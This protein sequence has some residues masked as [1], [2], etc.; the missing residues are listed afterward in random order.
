MASKIKKSYSLQM[1][2][3]LYPYIKPYRFVLFLAVI[4]LVINGA[5]D[6]GL[7]ALIKPLLDNGL[8]DKE[9]SLVLWI[10]VGIVFLIA[11]RGLTN[12]VSNYSLAW[13]SGKVV[14][15]F[16]QL[17]FAHYL[18]LPA[19]Y[20]DQKSIGDQISVIT[21]NAEMVSQAS[22][23][24]LI[25]IVRE[26][27]YGL[28]L[29]AVMFY[30]SWQ[31]SLIIL[32]VIPIV[33]FIA[34]FIAK[35]IKKVIRKIQSL[36]GQITTETD[37]M[38]KGHKEVLI[39]NAQAFEKQRF[40]KTIQN[41]RKTNLKMLAI[42]NL[43]SPITQVVAGIGLGLVIYTV[44]KSMLDITPGSF[45]L[46]FSAM[47]ALMR[48]MRELTNVHVQLQQGWI[49]CESLF[50]VLDL[51]PEADKGTIEAP[52]FNGKIEFRNVD[53]TYLT[54]Q[55][56]AIK[57]L[58]F[59]IQPNEKVAF[60]GRSGSGKSTIA[61]LLMRF[62]EPQ[63]GSILVDDIPIHEYQL[64]SYR[65][66]LGFVS[67]QVHLFHDS[68]TNNILYGA[69]DYSNDQIEVAAQK[70]HAMEFIEKLENGIETIVGDNGSLLSGGQKQRVAIARVLLRN[71][72]ILILDEAT[73][74]LDNQS[75]KIVQQ[76]FD[77]LATN[78]TTLIIAHRLSTIQNVDRIFVIDKGEILEEGSPKEL[79]EKKGLYAQMYHSQMSG[80]QMN[81]YEI[82]SDQINTVQ[83]EYEDKA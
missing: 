78:R 16:R 59:T 6:A 19:S 25:I 41:A 40:K 55:E 71:H 70:A 3:R 83:N 67:Q 23:N 58:S 11:L 45:T 8:M 7:L 50:T 42:S 26:L 34:N 15:N 21:Y 73:S 82:N 62:Y 47:V 17:V 12:Y 53:F 13:I 20:H 74:A 39:Y 37:Q 44:A 63:S 14:M 4:G 61:S 1:F 72:P 27:I 77:E 76:A 38:L 43:S 57:T 46:V 31:L 64:K 49:G 56:P 66:Q 32:I 81:T 24:A 10:A 29:L 35:R 48:P 33:V 60:V 18:K 36:V 75:E 51:P 79:L 5:V 2:K 80:S 69:A 28:G 22:A 52:R 68:I 65:S 9:Y 54:Q 30:G